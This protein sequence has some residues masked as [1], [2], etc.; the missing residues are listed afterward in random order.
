MGQYQIE[1]IEWVDSATY[2]G[3][4]DST[5]KIYSPM[6][7]ATCGYVVFENDTCVSLALT[8]GEDGQVADVMTIPKVC[9][10]SRVQLK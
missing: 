7:C 9:I 3:W 8:A 6:E 4:H 2:T 5:S 10:T 1:R